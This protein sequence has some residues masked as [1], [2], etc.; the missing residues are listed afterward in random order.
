M[1]SG[2]FPGG[3]LAASLAGVLFALKSS[4]VSPDVLGFVTAGDSLIAT[5]VGGFTVLVGPVVGAILYIYAQGKFGDTG[6]LELYM[7]LALIVAVVF[8]PG[9][10]TG[11][12]VHNFRRLRGALRTKGARR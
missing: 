3:L 11:F 7:G 2:A 6:N 9:G 1:A 5:L 10:I 4:Y 12:V 8:L